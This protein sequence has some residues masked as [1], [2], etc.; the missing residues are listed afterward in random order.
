MV[1]GAVPEAADL[2]V[3]GAGPGGYAAALHA[4]RRGRRVM[5]V[6][7]EGRDGV[8]GVCLREGCIPS[9]ALIE[10]ADLFRKAASGAERGI[11]TSALSADLC[12]FQSF[13]RRV[14]EG[15]TSGVRALLDAAEV[16]VV[17]GELSLVDETTAVIAQP[18]DRVRFVAFRDLVI[19]TG[20]AALELPELPFDGVR[21]LDSSAV[22]DL[23]TLPASLGI[24][25]AGYIGVEIG[26]ALA[27]LGTRVTVIEAADRVLPELP[28]HL[29][30]P[31]ARR[32]N[33]LGM[34][35]LP[36][37]RARTLRERG[38]EVDAQ[39]TPRRLEA[40]RVMVAV[41][42][43]PALGSINLSSAGIE[44]G[45]DGRLAVGPDRRVRPHIAAIGDLTPGPALAH[46]AY[47]EA[48]VAVDA[49]C[50]ENVAFEPAAIP[51]LVFSDP[52]IASLG[53]SAGPGRR[54][55]RFPVR[56]SGRAATLDE[57]LGFVEVVSDEEDGTVLGVHIVAPH[58]S[59]LIAEGALAVEM[60]A[61]R[62]DL[63]LTIHPH[64]TL[65]E[66]LGEAAGLGTGRALH[67]GRAVK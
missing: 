55:A 37:T 64:P 65:S 34:E 17:A 45:P 16:E 14:V 6:D 54:S 43:R 10:T 67:A 44:P 24:V 52:E 15:L 20:S 22:L 42:R 46:K 9:K 63:A 66:M 49:L 30:A 53:E 56:A 39:G 2:V 25:G 23:D 48:V 33:A 4:A 41:G 35:V 21:V 27:K 31:V 28:A 8:G 18:G 51:V 3:A 12:A 60:G 50:G 38:L 11:V 57:K 62:E 1:V 7:R 61:T 40:E 13:K 32:M 36:G 26:I 59:E 29:G 58:A 5:L 19:A 47:A